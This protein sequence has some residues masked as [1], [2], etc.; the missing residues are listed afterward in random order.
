M[1]LCKGP[2][3]AYLVAFFPFS[4]SQPGSIYS[5]SVSSPMV[6]PVKKN[7]NKEAKHPTECCVCFSVLWRD[8]MSWQGPRGRSRTLLQKSTFLGAPIRTVTGASP[9]SL[10]NAA[11]LMHVPSLISSASLGLFY[12]ACRSSLISCGHWLSFSSL[13]EGKRR[14]TSVWHILRKAESI[15][16]QQK[17]FEEMCTIPAP[18]FPLLFQNGRKRINAIW[19]AF[20]SCL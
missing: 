8:L 15:S 5:H 10:L 18:R 7:I 19:N 16:L 2:N 17:A 20:G 3:E 9:G 13:D 12:R 11:S 14:I 4:R 6:L 1:L